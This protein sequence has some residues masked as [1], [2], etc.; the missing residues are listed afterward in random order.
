[1]KTAVFVYIETRNMY[2]NLSYLRKV[3]YLGDPTQ[4]LEN[5]IKMDLRERGCVSAD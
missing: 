4:M 2:R 5:N 1:V 3:D